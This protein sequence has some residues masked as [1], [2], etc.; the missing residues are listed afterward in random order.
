MIRY[1]AFL[2][3]FCTFCFY[4]LTLFSQNLGQNEA[5]SL[6]KSFF[7]S[8]L[9]QTGNTRTFSGIAQ[10]QLI[11][12]GDKNLYYII[13][14]EE[15]GFVIIS[16]DKRFYPILAYAFDGNF[17]MDK[18]PENCNTWLKS[19]ESQ[20]CYALENDNVQLANYSKAWGSITSELNARKDAKGILPLTTGKWSQS[21]PHN[22]MCP[23]DAESYDG[24]APVGCVALAMSQ[25]MYYYRFPLSGAGTVL[26]TPPYQF[27][28]YGPQYV[29]F[30]EAVYQWPAM[31]D[32]CRE[33]N[34]AIAQLCYHAG[35]AVETGYMPESSGASINNVSDAFTGHFNYLA[36]E[37]LQRADVDSTAAWTA[38]LIENLE[39]KQPVLYRSSMGWGGH[40]YLCDGYQ[41][42]THF[43]FNWGWG[44]AYNGYFFIDNLVPGG[45]NINSGQGA[46]FNIYPDTTQFEF[47]DYNINNELLTNN[48]G[49]F[50]DGSANLDYL[51]ETQKSWLIQPDSSEITNILL[52]FTFLDTESDVDK[53]KIYD[54][55][56]AAAPLLA[57]VSG[58]N[59]PPSF[60]SSGSALFLT[61]ESDNQNQAQG[62]HANYYGYHLPFCETIPELTDPSGVLE[63]G[64]R[65]HPYISNTN[66]EW[67]IAPELS[68]IDSIAQLALHFYQLDLAE[69]DT[70]FMYD[71]ESAQAPLLG[72]F[73]GGSLP[74][75]LI[76]SGNKLFLNFITDS[77]AT[78]QGWAV[79]WDYI[80]PEYCHDTL[81]YSANADTLSD[82]S[83]EKNYIENTDCYYLIEVADA[84]EITLTFT[85][86]EVEANYDYLEIF[87]LSNPNQP[88]DKF[89]GFTLPQS[90][91]YTGKQFLL[92]FHSDY[93]DN[94]QGW[95]LVY[96]ASTSVISERENEFTI[97][98]NPVSD[99][100]IIDCPI[101]NN[102]NFYYQ[103]YHPNGSLLH[104][105]QASSLPAHL[106]FSSYKPGVYYLFVKFDQNIITKKI[107]K[108]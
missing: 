42:S 40:V 83:G 4:S 91:T 6:G 105:G 99:F 73:A 95:Q 37:Y 74:G 18:I 66:C 106:D 23:A 87:H 101:K 29:N 98:P 80:L 67:L 33:T 77:A 11:S 94:F 38:I 97:Y 24:H 15:N 58:N 9:K 63:D 10:C 102:E 89:S 39:N 32:L 96:Q 47:P 34:D 49:S 88:I 85:D 61:F 27:G 12:S 72:K 90:K 7:Q 57:V 5:M 52:E 51:P 84:D 28:V 81:Y 56:S 14:F 3:I 92:H 41:D 1:F 69:G 50:E 53:I 76:T 59:L 48:V 30:A 108:L 55:S 104:S 62:F 45:I 75:D 36:D 20:I 17:E 82:A 46:I 44:G 68:P 35:V 107:L 79:G 70:L 93:R 43:H 22:Q 71:G 21:A 54:G 78:S 2:L 103:I 25:L 26:Y 31:S 16:S 8:K 13:N 100:L 60:R 86:F 64:S 65:Y 19:W